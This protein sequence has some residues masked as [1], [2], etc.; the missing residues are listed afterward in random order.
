MIL[1]EALNQYLSAQAPDAPSHRE[2]SRFVRWAG[3]ERSVAKLNP[4]DVADYAEGVVAAGGDVH[5]RLT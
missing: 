5:S 1:S 4:P 3:L 2:L